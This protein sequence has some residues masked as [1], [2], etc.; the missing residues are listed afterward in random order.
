MGLEVRLEI[1]LDPPRLW[2][3]SIWTYYAATLVAYSEDLYFKDGI[4]YEDLNF[5]SSLSSCLKEFFW[6]FSELMGHELLLTSN[7][8]SSE[9]GGVVGVILLDPSKLHGCYNWEMGFGSSPLVAFL[10]RNFGL[11]FQFFGSFSHIHSCLICRFVAL[12]GWFNCTGLLL[13]ARWYI[14]CCME[15][16]VWEYVDSNSEAVWVADAGLWLSYILYWCLE[17]GVWCYADSESEMEML[18]SI[19]FVLSYFHCVY[20]WAVTGM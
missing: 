14:D 13:Q 5:F 7:T 18:L 19:V 1:S 8:V 11:R 4:F 20:T 10:L 17:L 12:F 9:Y 3:W 15:S 2:W 16:G 6:K